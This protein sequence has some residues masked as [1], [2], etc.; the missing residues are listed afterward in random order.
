MIVD[1]GVL[2]DIV[3]VGMCAEGVVRIGGSV[4]GARPFHGNGG[5]IGLRR[6]LD[7]CRGR[8]TKP[9]TASTNWAS[10]SYE[11]CTYLMILITCWA[12]LI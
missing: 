6:V 11:T 1:I 9:H 4:V 7:D 2:G 10:F 3:D 5:D 12:S 8:I